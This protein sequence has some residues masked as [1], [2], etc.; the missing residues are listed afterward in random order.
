[1]EWIRVDG[2]P[3]DYQRK[4][5]AATKVK[6]IRREGERGRAEGEREEGR[7]EEGKKGI[8]WSGSQ[9]MG[10]HQTTRE[11][12][13]RPKVKE[14][15]EEERG[16]EGE[17]EER[18]NSI[19][20]YIALG[21]DGYDCLLGCEMLVDEENGL[22]LSCQVRKYFLEVSRVLCFVERE[23]GERR[24]REGERRRYKND[25]NTDKVIDE[26]DTNYGP[27]TSICLQRA[28]QVGGQEAFSLY[29][30][31]SPSSLPPSLPLPL[32]LPSSFIYFSFTLRIYCSPACRGADH[33]HC[34]PYNNC[35]PQIEV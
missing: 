6:E 19:Q 32:P 34:K 11:N 4:Y 9:L 3:I 2:Q 26:S 25:I 15:G 10:S 13:L 20:G 5:T 28:G 30:L 35:Y 16:R 1:M 8:E 23:E 12:I 22:L 33:Q 27:Q 31:L 7:G 24:E 18:L 29:P 21:N 14:D 17:G